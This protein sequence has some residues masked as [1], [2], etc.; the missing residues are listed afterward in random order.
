MVGIL[1]GLD[2][3]LSIFSGILLG[4]YIIPFFGTKKS[5]IL[6]LFLAGISS[7]GFGLL[8][9]INH[10]FAFSVMCFVIKIFDSIGTSLV[11]I[12]LCIFNM[13]FFPDDIAI[14]YVS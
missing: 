10:L 2:G 6:G 8:D 7:L 14:I 5:L 1:F 13:K 12:S 4:R 3:F 11:Y 9:K